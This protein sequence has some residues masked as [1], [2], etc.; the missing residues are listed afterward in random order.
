MNEQD[1][2]DKAVWAVILITIGAALFALAFLA[3]V[4]N[5]IVDEAKMVIIGVE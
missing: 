2:D 3:L 5:G 4:Y 1:T